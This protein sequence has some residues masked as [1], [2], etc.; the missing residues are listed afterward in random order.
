M[1]TEVIQIPQSLKKVSMKRLTILKL[2]RLSLFFQN[3]FY[4]LNPTLKST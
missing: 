3:Y 2:K 4:V 1:K